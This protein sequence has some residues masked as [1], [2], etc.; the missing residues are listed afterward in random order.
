MPALLA[1][2]FF[3]EETRLPG[4][5]FWPPF[6]EGILKRPSRLD[7][8]LS[9]LVFWEKA[10]VISAMKIKS[11]MTRSAQEKKLVLL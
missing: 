6:F 3:F 2:E 1:T 5:F 11:P 10:G 7:A 8:G 4:F 9:P